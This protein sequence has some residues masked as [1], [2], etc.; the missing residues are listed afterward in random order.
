MNAKQ[1]KIK[2]IE[3]LESIHGVYEAESFFYLILED[4][5]QMKRLDLALD[6][7]FEFSAEAID[8][9]SF[10]MEHTQTKLVESHDRAKFICIVRMD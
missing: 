10:F 9:R 3:S 2:F 6:P 5:F 7:N 1:Y 8:D 4:K